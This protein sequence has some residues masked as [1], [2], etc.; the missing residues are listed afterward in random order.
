MK[1]QIY[2]F[3]II[4]LIFQSCMSYNQ[5]AAVVP[6]GSLDLIPKGA[7]T[8]IVQNNQTLAANYKA[9][10]L[11]LLSQDYKIQKQNPEM[12]YILAT[13]TAPGDTRVRLN[14]VCKNESVN[15]STDWTAGTQTALMFG[16]SEAAFSW[17]PAKWAKNSNKSTVAF[18]S[19]VKFA[20]SING[21]IRYEK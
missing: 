14:V 2:L 3:L 6:D 17:Y 20:K 21:T 16:G 12:G 18:V 8:I 1:K 4:G 11:A 10:Y 19:A 15:I 5:I 7:K 9:S 13:N